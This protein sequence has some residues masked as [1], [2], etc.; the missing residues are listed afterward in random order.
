MLIYLLSFMTAEHSGAMFLSSSES[1]EHS[2]DTFLSLSESTE[3]DDLYA[4]YCPHLKGVMKQMKIESANIRKEAEPLMAKIASGMARIDRI[5]DLLSGK[6]KPR[7]RAER[8][9]L[10]DVA[11]QNDGKIFEPQE[12][13]SAMSATAGVSP[14]ASA[15][16]TSSA[17]GVS[18]YISNGDWIPDSSCCLLI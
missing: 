16:A 9:P 6:I 14:A 8:A 2:S 12:I 11:E 7:P 17:A 18:P 13:S 5:G 1:A 4:A 10:A 15:T 3:T